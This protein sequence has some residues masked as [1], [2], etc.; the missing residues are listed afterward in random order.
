MGTSQDP[1]L[2][3]ECVVIAALQQALTNPEPI[4]S[5]HRSGYYAAIRKAL[6]DAA[7]RA[8]AILPAGELPQEVIKAIIGAVSESKAIEIH[9]TEFTLGSQE[10]FQEARRRARSRTP[11]EDQLDDARAM[12]SSGSFWGAADIIRVYQKDGT[13]LYQDG[14]TGT[15]LSRQRIKEL[16]LPKRDSFSAEVAKQQKATG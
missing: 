9:V 3:V 6:S 1:R 7:E 15:P 14:K 12:G 5:R 13:I 10:D 4:E 8:K 2:T 11:L 16:K